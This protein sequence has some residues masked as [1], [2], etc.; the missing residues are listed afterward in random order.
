MNIK[1]LLSLLFF[2]F[3]VSAVLSAGKNTV[4]QANRRTA[5]RCLKIAENYLSTNDWGNALAQAEL[6]IVYDQNIAD[7]WYVKAAAK[8]GLE[9][10]RADVLPLVLHALT[11]GEWVD[12]NKDGARILCA[13]ILCETGDADQAL[14][15]L[16]QK[17][18]IYSADAEFIRTKCFYR[19]GDN[20]SARGKVNA[21]RKIYPQ[22]LR[23]PLVFF[24]NEYRLTKGDVETIYDAEQASAV[25][26]IADSFIAKMPEYDHPDAELEIYAAIF[27]EGEHQKRL[28]QAFTAHGMKHPLYA[29]A[30]LRSELLSQQEA[31][32]YFCEF[33]DVAVSLEMLED[34]LLYVTDDVTVES[35]SEHLEAYNGRLSI[36]TDNDGDGNLFAQYVRGRPQFVSWDKNNDGILEWS[37]ECDFGVP[38][39]LLV[40]DGNL[41]VAYGTYPAIVNIQINA[42]DEEKAL[43]F[44][45]QDEVFYWTPMDIRALPIVSE[46]F[47]Y[48]FFVPYPVEN[49]NGLDESQIVRHCTF[50]VAP[51]RERP[52][53]TI[54]FSVVDGEIVSA[55]YFAKGKMFA[56]CIYEEGMPVLRS[57]DNDDDDVFET[58]ELYSSD[59]Q[60]LFKSTLTEELQVGENLFGKGV[61][62]I[63]IYLKMVQIDNNFDTVPDFTEEYS[64]DGGVVSS[65]DFDADGKWDIRYKKYPHGDKNVPLVEDSLFYLGPSRVLVTLTNVDGNPSMIRVDG[66]ENQVYPVTQG[67]K[68]WFYWIGER[69]SAEDETFVESEFK[70]GLIQGKSQVFVHEEKRIC[71]IKVEDKI[72]ASVVPAFGEKSGESGSLLDQQ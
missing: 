50:F 13:D 10:A 5:I 65:W 14:T 38:E 52:G 9:E 49:D 29:K 3:A 16:D 61:E 67:L 46:R 22:D 12:Y 58:V 69:G 8:S 17:P 68:N 53:A 30:A 63:G 33:A 1:K 56:H 57:I 43:S 19:L 35:V 21:A 18:F 44:N 2:L 15:I 23:F 64:S 71:V 40:S 72:F 32:D 4:Q 26:K 11:E 47:G 39:S 54:K 27:S 6:G 34:F 20:K 51:S 70:D 25:R 59:S 66:D 31:W 36:D 42:M 45:L 60:G 41:S 62:G 24:R 37:G 7:L 55:D 48:D 28:L